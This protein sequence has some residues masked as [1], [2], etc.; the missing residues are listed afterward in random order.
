MAEWKLERMGRGRYHVRDAN[1]S[2]VGGIIIGGRRR[3]T[4]E[5]GGRQWST[6]FPSARAAAAILADYHAAG[7]AAAET[8]A[9]ALF[10]YPRT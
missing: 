2:R 8:A 6:V 7:G 5:L 9:A 3:W 10:R 1:G 4:V